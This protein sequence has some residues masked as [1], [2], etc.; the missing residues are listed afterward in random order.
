MSEENCYRDFEFR[1]TPDASLTSGTV[2]EYHWINWDRPIC[3]QADTLEN[4]KTEIDHLYPADG[5]RA[6]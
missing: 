6:R 5:G 4:M 3:G 2:F 1:E